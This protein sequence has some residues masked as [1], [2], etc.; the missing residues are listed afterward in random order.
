MRFL[1]PL[2]PLALMACQPAG[3]PVAVDPA[4]RTLTDACLAEIGQ[5]PL[6]ANVTDTATLELTP[7]QQDAF[8]FCV[9]RRIAG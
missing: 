8:R 4:V 3:T 2:A 1:I 6:P 9:E 7:E 5:P